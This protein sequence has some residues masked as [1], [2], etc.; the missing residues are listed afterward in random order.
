MVSG[1][2]KMLLKPRAAATYARPM[3][4]LPLVGSTIT[5]PGLSAPR[6]IASPTIAIPMR[7]FTE[8]NGL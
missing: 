3:P 6:C 4:V 7:S 1:M 5:I 8:L 2:T